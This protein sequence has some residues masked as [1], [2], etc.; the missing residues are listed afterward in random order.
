MVCSSQSA[1]CPWPTWLSTFGTLR[2]LRYILKM[3]YAPEHQTS[4]KFLELEQPITHG[5]KNAS[6]TRQSLQEEY[7]SVSGTCR[8]QALLEI[9][10][11]AYGSLKLFRQSLNYCLTDVSDRQG[12]T[13]IT[14]PT[15]HHCEFLQLWPH[16]PEKSLSLTYLGI[17]VRVESV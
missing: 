8:P 17:Y 16:F 9:L 3:A 12:R 10:E 7:T 1:E 5:M 11:N 14:E 15:A 13:E 2:L 6:E 4:I